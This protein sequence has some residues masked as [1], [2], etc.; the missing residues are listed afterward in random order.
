MRPKIDNQ[1]SCFE[2]TMNRHHAPHPHPSALNSSLLRIACARSDAL[3][4]GVFIGNRKSAA[5]TELLLPRCALRGLT[6]K[7][8]AVGCKSVT[9]M[10]ARDQDRM[11]DH[12]IQ[13]IGLCGDR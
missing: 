9:T 3:S 8:E 2:K 11:V 1:T 10:S 12:P 13:R 4:E 7:T 6:L 5:L